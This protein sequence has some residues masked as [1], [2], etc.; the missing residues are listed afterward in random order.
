MNNNSNNNPPKENKEDD[1]DEFNEVPE[2][3]NNN[4]QKEQKK[5]GLSSLLDSNLVNLDSLNQPQGNR[6]NFTFG[7]SSGNGGNT[8][9]NFY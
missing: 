3:N 1:D 6:N 4:N 7:K 9:F 8:N 2:N 5:S